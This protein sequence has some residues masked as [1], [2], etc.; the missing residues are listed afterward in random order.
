MMKP[1]QAKVILTQ[2]TDPALLSIEQ[3]RRIRNVVLGPLN[4]KSRVATRFL[5][6]ASDRVKQKTAEAL[7]SPQNFIALQEAIKRTRGKL[8]ME[9]FLGITAVEGG[10]VVRNRVEDYSK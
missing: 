5:E 9:A 4:H 2:N 8:K 1:D 6:Y 7:L 3:A 10:P